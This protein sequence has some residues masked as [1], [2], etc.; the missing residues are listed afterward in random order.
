M[1]KE[2][3]MKDTKY[4]GIPANRFSKLGGVAIGQFV[5]K[6][7]TIYKSKYFVARATHGFITD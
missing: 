6:H 2:L 1:Q 4:S 3:Y 5:A 7:S